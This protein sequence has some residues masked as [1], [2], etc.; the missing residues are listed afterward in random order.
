MCRIGELYAIEDSV[1]G[2]SAELCRAVRSE[3]AQPLVD[4]LK[5]WLESEV[6]RVA[7]RSPLADALRYALVRWDDLRRFL[8][9]GRV[10]LDTNTVARAIRPIVLGRKNHLFA[11]SDGGADRWTIVDSLIIT[12]KLNDREPY[13]YLKDVLE[14]MIGGHPPTASMNS[15]PETGSL[16]PDRGARNAGAA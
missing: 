16:R 11:G 4:A 2:R 13:A 8:D 3:L 10:E 6:H 7:L 9:D 1:R 5:L 14:R 15:C 12:A